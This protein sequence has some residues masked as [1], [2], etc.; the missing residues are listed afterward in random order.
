MIV[1]YH[2]YAETPAEGL[3]RKMVRGAFSSGAHLVKIACMVNPAHRQ[4][5]LLDLLRTKAH[6]GGSIVVG[7]GEAGRIT[8]VARC[9]SAAPSPTPVTTTTGLIAPGQM[10][11]RHLKKAMELIAHG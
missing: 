2:N 5:R 8:R 7:M 10:G 3:L 11:V 1:S 9:F 6:T 4:L